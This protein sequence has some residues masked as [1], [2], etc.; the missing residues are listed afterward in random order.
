MIPNQRPSSNSSGPR[1]RDWPIILAN[2]L[3]AE[4]LLP[5]LRGVKQQSH[6]QWSACCPAHRDTNPSLSVKE[7]ADFKVLVYCHSHGCSAK[8][9]M[10]AVGLKMRHLYPTEYAAHCARQTGKRRPIAINRSKPTSG[11]GDTRVPDDVV[12]QHTALANECHARA[13]AENLLPVLA[14]QLRLNVQALVDFRVGYEIYK[15]RNKWVFLERDDDYRIIALIRRD[16]YDSGKICVPGGRRGLIFAQNPP[17][18]ITNPNAPLYIAEGHT[19]TIALHGAGCL[20]IGRPAAWLSDFARHL[21]IK[22]LKARPQVWQPRPI[23]VTAD[24]DPTGR[25]GAAKTA[26]VLRI[27]LGKT[28]NVAFPPP[29]HNDMRD[30]IASGTFTP[31]WPCTGLE[32]QQ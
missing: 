4:I 30:W 26:E 5:R 13:L 14:E 27:W 7:T 2:D 17:V 8:E 22:F 16:H 29:P 21:L 19:D 6:Q 23:V 1:S 9:I 15:M 25:E 11:G 32:V 28:I 10:A 20:A 24:N 18:A 3:P 12:Q 31:G